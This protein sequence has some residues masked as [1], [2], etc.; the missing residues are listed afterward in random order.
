MWISSLNRVVIITSKTRE[1]YKDV[2]VPYYVRSI[3]IRSIPSLHNAYNIY[4]YKFIYYLI[5]FFKVGEFFPVSID[6][7]FFFF[8]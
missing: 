8:F 6:I 5:I 4:V 1:T 2:R 3:R 7:S